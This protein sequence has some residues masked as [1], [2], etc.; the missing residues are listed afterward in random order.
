MSALSLLPGV[1]MPARFKG[2]AP[3]IEIHSPLGAL[4]RI[5]RRGADRFGQRNL[6]AGE[7]GDET[8]A[9][10]LAAR[11]HAAIDFQE[12]PPRRQ[13][14]APRGRAAA[15][16]PRRSGAAACGPYARRRRR[17][18][19]DRRIGWRGASVPSGRHCPYRTAGHG[20]ARRPPPSG[21]RL[22]AGT[23]SARK[24]PK[25]SELTRPRLTSSPSA[26]STWGRSKPLSATTSSKKEA[27]CVFSTSRT[28]A[29]RGLGSRLDLFHARERHPER[30][31]RRSITAIGVV[32]T[33]EATRSLSLP[34]LSLPP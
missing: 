34:S 32:R 15:R 22:S 7:A 30:A 14:T 10:N 3:E 9:T 13:G 31:E 18:S 24:P 1:R 20:R 6:L 11:F 17:G 8:A 2:S 27:P 4:R 16:T 28:V 19:S 25:L 29:A 23:S 5:S 26:S 12:I 21:L 33:G